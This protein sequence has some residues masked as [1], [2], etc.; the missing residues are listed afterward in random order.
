MFAEARMATPKVLVVYYSQDGMTRSVASVLADEL[1][2]PVEELVETTERT[3][4]F[5][6]LRSAYEG[7]LGRTTSLKRVRHRP[8]DYDLVVVGTPIWSAAVSAPVRTYLE[9]HHL[10]FR[11]LAF[12]ATG[13]G[14]GAKRVFDQMAALAVSKPTAVL[15]VYDKDVNNPEHLIRLRAFAS[16]LRHVLRLPTRVSDERTAA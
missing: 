13:A 11:R 7:L 9:Q 1:D 12:F 10:N 5:S 4:K 2:C 8:E 3:G 6:V 14:F 15:A 16:R